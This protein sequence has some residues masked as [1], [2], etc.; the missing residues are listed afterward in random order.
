MKRLKLLILVFCIAIS[1]PL[2]HVVRQSFQGLAEEE[3]AQLRFFSQTLFDEMEKTLAER[4]REEENR[5]VDEYHHTLAADGG[6]GSPSPLARV[7]REEYILGYLQNN[8]DGSFQTPLVAD[9][10]RVPE[11]QRD[12]VT[13][14]S[15]VNA[16]FNR[17]K[18]AL[19]VLSPAPESP[20][21][22]VLP[23]E[24]PQMEA[25][26]EAGKK[27][28]DGFADRYLARSREQKTKSYLGQ[29][30]RRTEEI[31]AGQAL[32]LSREDQ[33]IVTSNEAREKGVSSVFA[34]RDDES[35]RFLHR[36]HRP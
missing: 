30:N 19:A 13:Q 32:N 20:A 11:E 23:A 18:F 31:T 36:P 10:G 35:A 8:P 17:K 7:P 15:T 5:A 26:T 16:A 12:I 4:V 2:A 27:E 25:E 24:A 21:R 3:R 34:M 9:P 33:A 6:T 28:K 1:L 22:S 14:L 29:K